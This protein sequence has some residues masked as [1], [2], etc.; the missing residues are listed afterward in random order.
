MADALDV[1]RSNRSGEQAVVADAMEAAGQHVQEKVADELG[2][3]ECHGREPV[4]AFDAVVL[5]LESDASFVE[6]EETGIRDRDTV[7]VSGEIGENGLR[8]GERPL[9]VDDPL[10]AAERGERGVEGALLGKRCEFAEEDQGAGGV[11]ACEAVEEEAAE[12]A[13]QHTHRRKKPPLQATQREPSDD[14][15]P[16]GT[17]TWTWG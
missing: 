10:G 8:S 2:G 15:P 12:Q 5:P 3:V 1:A 9:G 16:P 4:A 7:G 11:Q 13:R 17:M 14:R 6:R